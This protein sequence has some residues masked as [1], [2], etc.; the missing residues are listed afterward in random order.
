MSRMAFSVLETLIFAVTSSKRVVLL[1]FTNS[2]FRGRNVEICAL[3]YSKEVDLLTLRNRV[4][5]A[6][7]SV[8]RNAFMKG[9]RF[10]ETQ[11]SCFEAWKRLH[12]SCS[13]QLCGRI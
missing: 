1:I 4:L 10:A 11:E 6:K 2:G 12:K 7:R 8:M 9:R 13:V 3:L 5:A